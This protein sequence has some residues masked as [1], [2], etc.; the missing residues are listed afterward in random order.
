[1]DSGPTVGAKG[2]VSP[3]EICARFRDVYVPAVADVLDDRGLWHQVMDNILPLAT[4]MK[5]AGTAFTA[6]GRPERSTDRSIR[7]GAKMIDQMSQGE[8]AVFDCSDDRTVG[9]WGELLTNG[10]LARG[11]VGAV[12]DGGVRD[13]ATVL[14]MGFPV[15]NRF[16][17]AR[18]A[19]GRWNVVDMQIPIVCGG[20]LVRPGDYIVGD[21][22]GVVVVPHEIA[23][24]VLVDAE[25]TVAVESEIRARVRAGEKVG[26]LYMSYER[27]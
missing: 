7:L 27:F 10:A 5:V 13:T 3:S 23:A 1:M 11:A 22:D 14:N 20:V 6:L 17:S 9:H 2:Q 16:R 18:D 4:D 24:E 25:K 26:D 12:I 8:V 21:A 15:F 19:R